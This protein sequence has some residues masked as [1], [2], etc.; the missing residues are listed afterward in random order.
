MAFYGCFIKFGCFTFNHGKG[1]A[2]AFAQTSAQTV[3]VGFTHQPG[4]ALDDFQCAFRASGHTLPATVA[5]LV[6]D[7]DN[8]TFRHITILLSL[9]PTYAPNIR[10]DLIYVKD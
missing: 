6:V 4:L 10:G 5:F 9:E 1:S 2:R 8:I 3:A 7:L